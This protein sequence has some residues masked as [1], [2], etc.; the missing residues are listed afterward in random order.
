MKKKR[1]IKRSGVGDAAVRDS[2]VDV[3]VV[4][5]SRLVSSPHLPASAGHGEGIERI[6]QVLHVRVVVSPLLYD[7]TPNN[8]EPKIGT[9]TAY[10]TSMW[11]A[12]KS[13]DM[14]AVVGTIYTRLFMITSFISFIFL[15]FLIHIR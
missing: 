13:M 4:S 10:Y 2:R 12:N 15:H 14:V 3:I 6:T 11:P 5:L 8:T 9:H 7:A 1:G